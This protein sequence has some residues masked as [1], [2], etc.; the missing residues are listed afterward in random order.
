MI[1]NHLIFSIIKKIQQAEVGQ[2]R[3]KNNVYILGEDPGFLV[4]HPGIS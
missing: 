2:G 1:R 4:R 3:V